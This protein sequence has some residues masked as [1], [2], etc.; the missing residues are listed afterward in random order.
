M[1]SGDGMVIV[2]ASLA[3]V[4]AAEA[5]RRGGYDGSITVVG[6]ELHQPYDRP[7][8]SK[9]LLAGKAEPE[10]IT[11][12]VEEDLGA[13]WL[14]GRTA[15]HLDLERQRLTLNGGESLAYEGLVIATGAHPRHL[16]L[17]QLGGVHVLRTL[18]D[19]LA[20]RAELERG[21]PVVVIGAGFIGAEVAATCRNRGLEVTVVELLD[22]PLS[23]AIGDDM[24]R[25]C[26]Q[27]HRDNGTDLRLGTAVAGLVGTNRV[28]GVT[29]DGGGTVDADVV[30]VGV[31][32]LPTVNWLEGSGVDLDDGVR[33]DSRCRVLAGGRPRPDVVAAGDVARWDHPRWGRAVRLEHWTNAIE[34]GEAA[35]ATLLA[36]DG[37]PEF[38]PTPYFWSDQYRTKIQFVGDYQEGDEVAV[39]EGSPDAGRFVAGYGRDGR[40]VGGLGFSRP[41]RVMAYRRMI[42]EGTPW[43]LPPTDES[44]PRSS[45]S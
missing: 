31:G 25:L 7:P 27:L 16:P 36:G 26:A 12:P 18:D 35:A 42:A 13:S 8:L 40:Q 39:T 21:G 9:Q 24:G 38:A 29:L 15:T 22:V 19:S 20:L 14:L 34:Q 11:L 30:V 17:P 45:S 2:G 23:R 5:L 37:A 10:A 44:G 3:G 6:A 1:S 4:R 32:V 43:P 28:E 33:C 41:P